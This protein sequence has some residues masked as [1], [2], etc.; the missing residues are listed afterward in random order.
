MNVLDIKKI[1]SY[2]GIDKVRFGMSPDEVASIWGTAEHGSENFLNE[3]VEFR[4]GISTTYSHGKMLVEVGLPKNCTNVELNN[5]PIFLPSKKDRL[6]QLLALDR[7]PM[8][9]VGMIVFKD[10]SISITGF[11]HSDDSDLA[12]S[13]FSRGRWDKDFKT[14]TRYQP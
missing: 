11:E 4:N 6:R 5:I 14:M 10:L 2:I 9:D 12:M 13:V 3:L 8:E 7:S 1:F